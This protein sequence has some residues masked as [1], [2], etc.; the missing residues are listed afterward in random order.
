M[1][2]KKYKICAVFAVMAA[3]VVTNAVLERQRNFT[4]K[5]LGTAQEVLADEVLRLHVL[6]N[7]DEKWD[8]QVKLLV[9]DSVRAYVQNY[10]PNGLSSKEVKV[11]AK[12]QLPALEQEAKEVLQQQGCT[13]GVKARIVKCYFP[14]RKYED[15]LYPKGYYQALRIELGEA[16]GKNWWCVLYPNLCFTEAVCEVVDSE[17]EELEYEEANVSSH[18]KIKSFFFECFRREGD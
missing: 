17:K 12:D 7:S 8:Q 16:S 15:M 11:W 6:A 9:R 2:T 4:E 18:F 14:D 13:Y 3:L 5:T 10:I 1:Q